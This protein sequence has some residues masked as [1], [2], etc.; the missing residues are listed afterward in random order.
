MNILV[1]GVGGG[2]KH[3]LYNTA[4]RAKELT[5][6]LRAL[7]LLGDQM[8]STQMSGGSQL[9]ATAA[10]ESDIFFWPLWAPSHRRHILLQTHVHA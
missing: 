9:L 10:S 3:T 2:K 6:Y 7:V 1:R 5:Q 4:I 8:P